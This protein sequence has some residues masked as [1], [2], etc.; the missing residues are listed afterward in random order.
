VRVGMGRVLMPFFFVYCFRIEPLSACHSPFVY[1]CVCV[2]FLSFL[3]LRFFHTH[4]VLVLVVNIYT[5]VSK[6][7]SCL[8]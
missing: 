1:G 4:S 2:C 6:K 5:S 8:L 7:R 3:F